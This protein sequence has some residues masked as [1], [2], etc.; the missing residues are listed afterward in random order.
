VPEQPLQN[1]DIVN[2]SDIISKDGGTL[3]IAAGRESLNNGSELLLNNHSTGDRE[4]SQ[5][6]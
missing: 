6:N 3:G 1:S 2:Q 4:N 5:N